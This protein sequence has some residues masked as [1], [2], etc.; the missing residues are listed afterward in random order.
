MLTKLFKWG[1]MAPAE[2]PWFAV[3]VAAAVALV[4]NGVWWPDRAWVV[5]VLTVLG[6]GA[7]FKLV[8]WLARARTGR[9]YDEP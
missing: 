4:V 8:P 7:W 3:Q 1:N 9:P 6:V 5:Y 2:R